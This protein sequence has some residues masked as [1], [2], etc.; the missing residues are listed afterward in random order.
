MTQGS[1][2][3]V[4]RA[5]DPRG[6]RTAPLM[7]VMRT[8]DRGV[9]FL[10][11]VTIMVVGTNLH[12]F[13]Y[14]VA[15]DKPEITPEHIRAIR[16]GLGLSQVEAGEVLGGGPRAFTKYEAGTV[17][18][19]AAVVRLL[20]LLEANPAAIASLGARGSRPMSGGETA[21]FEVTGEHIAVLTERMLPL[22]LRRLLNAEAQAH[23]L[24]AKGIHVAGNINTADGGE[25][26]RI[27]WTGGPERTPFLPGRLCQFQLKAGQTTPAA[28]GRDVLSGS[29]AVKDMVRLALQAGG[30]YIMLCAHSYVQKQIEGREGRIRGSLR[31]AGLTIDDEQ[32]DFRDADQIADWVNHHPSVAVWVKEQTQ[33][34]T[35]GPFRSWVHWAGRVEHD[36]SPWVE[37]ERSPEL[38][39]RLRE[40]VTRPRGVCRVVGLSGIGKS[41]LVLESLGPTAEDEA[42]G[43]FLSDLVLYAVESEAGSGAINGVVQTLADIGQRTVVVVD[44]CASETHRILAGMVLRH[45]SRLSLVTIDDEIPAGTLD[46]TV[47]KVPEAP[48][49]VT[50]AILSRVSP[51]LPSEDQR[52]LV[53]FSRGFPKIAIRVGQAWTGR[54]PLAHAVDDDLVDAFVL[55]RSAWEPELARKAAALLATFGLV[56]MEHADDDRIGE[57]AA[58]GRDLTAA[59]LRAAIEHLIDRGA[60]QRRGRMA[61][62][63][64]RPIAMKL[65]ERQWRE[66]S[67]VEWDAVLTGGGNSDLKLLAA[68]QLAW[69]NTTDIAQQI[70]RHVCRPGGPFDGSRGISRAGNAEVLSTL[71]E[72]NTEV[73]ADQIE[74][75]LVNV[76]DLSEI[77]GEVCRHLVWALEK[78]AFHPDSF[79]E[80][81][82]LLLRLAVAEN[83]TWHDNA[84]GHFKDLFP[85]LLG[86]T[87]ADGKARLSVL[88]EAAGT[89]DPIQRMVIVEALIA[90]SGTVHF[91]RSV[92]AETHGSRPALES[93]H[94]STKAEMADYIEG[95]VTLLVEFAIRDDESGKTARTGL[96]RNL[97]GL[98]GSGFIDTVETVVRPVGAE[99][100]YWPEALESLGRFLTYDAS[101]MG[102]DVT[103]RV[104]TLVA[105]LTPESLESRVRLLVTD[106]PWGYLCG[107]GVDFETREKRRIEAV[108]ALAADLC[109]HPEVLAAVLPP[110]SRG[111]HRM[112]YY[113]GR[114]IA[115]FV[116][117]PPDWLESLVV[118]VVGAPEDERN[119]D[120]LSGYIAGIGNDFPDIVESFKRRA[121]QSPELAPALPLVCRRLGVGPS[122]V[123]LV[124]GALEAGLLPPGQLIHWTIGGALDEVPA[125]SLASLF[126]AMLDHSAEAFG[127]AVDLM[128]MYTHGAPGK[129]ED[130]RAQ[131]R[132]TVENLS[133]WEQSQWYPMA[134]HHFEEIT[135]WILNKGRQDS[136]ARAVAF[137]LAVA[138]VNAQVD[139]IERLMK[140]LMPELLSGF[141]E[142][143][144]PLIG[145]AIVS[146]Q[147]QAWRLEHVLR[148]R[149]SF[150]R[151]GDP[152]LLSLPEETLFAWCHAHPDRAPAFVAAAVPVLTTC[153]VSAT[154]GSLHPVVVWL[155]DEFG[156][157][158]GVLQAITRNVHT[159]GWCGSLTTYFALYERPLNTLRHHPKPKVCRWAKTTLRRLT[160]EIHN[161]NNEDEE[162]EAQFE[163]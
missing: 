136:D 63:Q 145:Q 36:G 22:L 4:A 97:R 29:S 109:K 33:P 103:H 127:V 137:A 67:R 116:D 96:G 150:G 58:R 162:R 77:E 108:D 24:P 59:D 135:K 128:G 11:W 34:G 111:K 84:T 78:I 131:I 21:P 83:Q 40:R 32:V 23:G 79:E 8:S 15:R 112:A 41:R 18:P 125:P 155:L 94:P 19:A 54:R 124:A 52:R 87:A 76:E 91:S 70:V 102:R 1:S 105:E 132:K 45:G 152:A 75:S 147:Q 151:E 3:A 156:D 119:Y 64:P 129:L 144:W 100:G 158:E 122:D 80:G 93:W 104:N 17:K 71:A 140:P 118:A 44:R 101:R 37:D 163:I 160:A 43:H 10:H 48:S 12:H 121:A 61:I 25:D 5:Q 86:N 47:F 141:P 81:A 62:L 57:I 117:S 39:P 114:A 106:M 46:E 50:E 28:A 73:V 55:G 66:W 42:A 69:V 30:H 123:G 85:V 130:L 142:I 146:N 26:G 38:R 7:Q 31:S 88:D 153:Q 157:R 6:V 82:R 107:E 2:A 133:R 89:D 98:I 13:G 60:A 65:A 16:E 148:D 53:R 161:A 72:I 139:D 134:D 9:A 159:F 20:R 92:G 68:R 74:R 120:L 90:G 27:T 126:D 51:G 99:A 49:S 95:C 154:E 56:G 115:D 149:V 143:A 110:L 138:V 14:R 113:F 35:I